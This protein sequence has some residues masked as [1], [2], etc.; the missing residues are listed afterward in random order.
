[1]ASR[2]NSQKRRS[3]SRPPTDNTRPPRHRAEPAARSGRSPEKPAGNKPA[4]N[5]QGLWLYGIHAV[6]SA[7]ANPKRRC[8]RLI[9]TTGGEESLPS[10]TLEPEI[11]NRGA[12]EAVLP[13]GAVHQGVALQVLPLE[14][15]SIEDIIQHADTNGRTVIVVL[16]QVT[17]P[18]NVGAA[19]RSAAAFGAFAVVAPDRNTPE[20][21]GA[22]AKAASGALETVPLIRPNNLVRSLETLKEN[23]FWVLGLD[24]DA[25]I[26]LAEADL[27]ER[28]VFA[29]GAEGRGLRRLTRETCDLMVRVPITGAVESL[30][31]S[32]SA[33]VA[34]YEWV[35]ATPPGGTMQ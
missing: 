22:M 4:G 11:I 8:L 27:P 33:A 5:R 10:S 24:M 23:G 15:R 34:L 31:V 13:P 28:C 9:A 1:M 35:R 2:K 30:N 7:L 14:P 3:G 29:L 12:I 6:S 32:A 26:S 21:T 17:D 16:D 20:A 19:L 25:P 18:Q